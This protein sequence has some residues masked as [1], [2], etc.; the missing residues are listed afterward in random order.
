ME[1]ERRDDTVPKPKT[2]AQLIAE[3]RNAFGVDSPSGVE[4]SSDL[5]DK[6]RDWL[7]SDQTTEGPDPMVP[8]LA[9]E[10]EIEEEV[11]R[12]FE[13]PPPRPSSARPRR[14]TRPIPATPPDTGRPTRR[15]RRVLGLAVV[16]GVVALLGNVSALFLSSESDSDPVPTP[17]PTPVVTVSE[18]SISSAFDPCSGTTVAG[19]L[20]A[21][22]TYLEDSDAA[23]VDVEII[24]QELIGS[25][26]STYYLE[27]V[28]ST[29]GDRGQNEFVFESDFMVMTRDDGVEI[30]DTATFTIEFDGPNATDWSYTSVGADCQA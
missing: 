18:G 1:E 20:E 27:L 12:L 22:I 17:T 13:K 3:A 6:A 2:S 14:V 8:A 30:I 28:G 24:G 4:A 23:F 29:T 9:V 21:E 7:A 16:V 11:R 25:D 15:R 19:D 10:P 26:G 5:M